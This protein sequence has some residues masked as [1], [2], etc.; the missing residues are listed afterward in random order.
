MEKCKTADLTIRPDISNGFPRP[1]SAIIGNAS[2]RILFVPIS[3][4]DFPFSDEDLERTK[5]VT[6]EVKE[7]YKKTTYGKVS[8]NFDFLE[9]RFWV[10]MGQ[11]AA[12]YNLIE[13]K[14]QQNNTQVV[15]DALAQVDSS[16]DFNLYDGV[17]VESGRFQSTGGGQGFPGQ[18]FQTRNGLA[19]GVSLGFGRAVAS[20]GTLAHEFGHS[21]FGLEDLYVFLNANRPSVSDPQP[22]G[23]WD[24]M[25]SSFQ[26]FF[27]WNKYLNGWFSQNQVRCL[28]NQRSTFHYLEEISLTSENAKL[29]L[30]NI[31]QGVTVGI[32]SRLD[33]DGVGVLVYKIDSR[34]AH[35]DGPITA[36]KQLLRSGQSLVIE[37]WQITVRD[38]DLSGS[39]IEVVRS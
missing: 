34:I 19:R 37:N 15:V 7:F 8:I 30:I 38:T 28:D 32:E 31:Q 22:A 5:R 17:F 18:T 4:T 23:N 6:D 16:I 11:S 26:E 21:L 39:L 36:Q 1:T 20:F 14:P 12:S 33:K 13:N 27:G 9:K 3:F 29:A 25:S 24:M 35:G 2:V 10:A